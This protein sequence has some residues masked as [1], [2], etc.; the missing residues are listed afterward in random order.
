MNDDQ[1]QLDE[2][3]LEEHL[4]LL[5]P[6]RR[7][8]LAAAMRADPDLAERHRRLGKEFLKLIISPNI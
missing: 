3:L 6:R 8:E 4:D 1:H 2:R 7:A 5:S